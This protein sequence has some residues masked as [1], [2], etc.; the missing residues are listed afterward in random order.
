MRQFSLAAVM[1]VVALAVGGCATSSPDVV[2]RGD[3]QRMSQVE[4]GVILSVR[5]IT[6]D[7]SQSGVGTAAGG[8]IGAVAGSSIGGRRDSIV[9]GVLGAVVGGMIGNA[10]ER[11]GT[12]EDG[13]ELII[14]LKGGERRAVVQSKGNDISIQVTK[15]SS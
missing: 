6:I 15:S 10:V 12:R 1:V 14:E 8:V 7:G 5:N 11:Q 4:D 13:V 2:Q 3:A 9:G